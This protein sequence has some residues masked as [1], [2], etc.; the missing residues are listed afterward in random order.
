[1]QSLPMVC[2][3]IIYLDLNFK[4][5][6]TKF[7]Q[8]K[9]CTVTV[10]QFLIQVNY[11]LGLKTKCSKVSFKL[12]NDLTMSVFIYFYWVIYCFFRSNYKIQMFG[13]SY[14]VIILKHGS[15]YLQ[16]VF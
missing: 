6:K 16:P 5:K 8:S 15:D 4:N 7:D 1:M 14:S 13:Y 2:R 11:S 12:V 10:Y 3:C 9:C